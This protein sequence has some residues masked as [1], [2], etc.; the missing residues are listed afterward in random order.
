[1]LGNKRIINNLKDKITLKV[2]N[3]IEINCRTLLRLIWLELSPNI[4]K[5]MKL[6]SI[7]DSSLK[8]FL[9]FFMVLSILVLHSCCKVAWRIAV[10]ASILGNDAGPVSG[11]PF[12]PHY[13]P[14]SH[15]PGGLIQ[16]LAFYPKLTPTPFHWRSR[17][18]INCRRRRRRWRPN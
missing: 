18:S 4:S 12:H 1:M 7:P 3:D 2:N 10:P 16:P 11:R 17:L 15:E 9:C 8:K 6:A 13:K 14:C 5:C